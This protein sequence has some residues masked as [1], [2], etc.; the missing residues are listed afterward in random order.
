MIDMVMLRQIEKADKM[1]GTTTAMVLA[2]PVPVMGARVVRLDRI[3]DEAAS[4][5]ANAAVRR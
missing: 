2:N 1:D 4:G 5:P 3:Q